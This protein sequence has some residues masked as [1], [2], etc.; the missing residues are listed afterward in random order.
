MNMPSIKTRSDFKSRL[1]FF[2]VYN[3]SHESLNACIMILMSL[4]VIRG[5]YRISVV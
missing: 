1:Y 5:I 2:I 4:A 3:K